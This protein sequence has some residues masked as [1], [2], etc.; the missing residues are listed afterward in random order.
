L[1][2]ASASRN[3]RK[4]RQCGV[5][6]E[7]LDVEPFDVEPLDIEPDD[8]EPLDIAPLVFFIGFFFFAAVLM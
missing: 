5:E 3:A 4:D 7:S 2:V 8:M 6:D 1:G